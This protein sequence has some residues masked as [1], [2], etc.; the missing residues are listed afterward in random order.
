MGAAARVWERCCWEVCSL[1]FLYPSVKLQPPL[2]HHLPLTCPPHPGV[3]LGDSDTPT[4]PLKL[5]SPSLPVF[6]YQLDL[7]WRGFS[8]HIPLA[9]KEAQK[10]AKPLFVL[11][12]WGPG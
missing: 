9:Q 4:A 12:G 5:A 1:P 3:L 11:E 7:A 2:P 10:P 8:P 6:Y